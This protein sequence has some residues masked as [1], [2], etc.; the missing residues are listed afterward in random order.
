MTGT[1]V[2]MPKE[3]AL[4]LL[5]NNAKFIALEAGG[6][7]NWEWY[8]DS[9]QN[10]LE[11]SFSEGDCKANDFNFLDIAVREISKYQEIKTKPQL[12][13]ELAA[14]KNF[15]YCSLCYQ[16]NLLTCFHQLIEDLY[17]SL[18]GNQKEK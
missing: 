10:Y 3:K 5:E 14:L 15:D 18:L 2:L 8:G 16:D 9:L 7:D 6:V 11:R 12:L 17:K 13:T 4:S 1:Y